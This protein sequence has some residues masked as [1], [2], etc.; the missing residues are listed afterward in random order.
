[1]DILYSEYAAF[2]RTYIIGQCNRKTP[3][4]AIVVALQCFRI[5][6]RER[7]DVLVTTGSM[8]LAILACF[9]KLFGGKV[10]WVDSV[11]RVSEMS[12]SGRI[13][14]SFADLCLVQIETLADEDGRVEFAGGL[15]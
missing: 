14:R 11:A 6:L 15:L 10:V 4:S 5:T 12:L 2:G 13:V 9:M 8:P 3:F 1:M 7:P